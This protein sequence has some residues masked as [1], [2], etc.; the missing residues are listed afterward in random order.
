[1]ISLRGFL[2]CCALLAAPIAAEAQQ[3]GTTARVGVLLFS[4]PETDPNLPAFREGLR[5][6]GYVEGRN[7][8]LEYRFAESKAER[9]RRMLQRASGHR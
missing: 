4:T 5:Q 7:I 9:L 2:T 3:P 6:L 1:M 8:V